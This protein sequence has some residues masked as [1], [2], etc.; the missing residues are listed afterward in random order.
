[1]FNEYDGFPSDEFFAVLLDS[2]ARS[3]HHMVAYLLG[4]GQ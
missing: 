2:M 4:D 1:M 3:S